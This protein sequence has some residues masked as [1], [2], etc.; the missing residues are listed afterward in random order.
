MYSPVYSSLPMFTC[1]PK[2]TRVYLGL[3]LSSPSCLPIFTPGYSYLPM[4]TP[5]NQCLQVFKY[6]YFSCLPMF[7]LCTYVTQH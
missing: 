2:F 7:T 6:V 3:A 1:F 5:V 4:L